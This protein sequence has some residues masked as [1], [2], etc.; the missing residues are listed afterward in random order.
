M[1]PV[2]D[3]LIRAFDGLRIGFW[4]KAGKFANASFRL[5]AVRLLRRNRK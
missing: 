2:K 4:K 1:R 3:A 5:P